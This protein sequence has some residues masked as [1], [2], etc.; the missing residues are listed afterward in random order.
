MVDGRASHMKIIKAAIYLGVI[1]FLLPSPPEQPAAQ[2]AALGPAGATPAPQPSNA[3][4]LAA[5]CAGVDD[6]SAFCT[7]QPAVCDTAR[8]LL[9]TLEAKAKYGI[10]LLYQWAE[11]PEPAAAPGAEAKLGDPIT[12]STVGGHQ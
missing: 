1:A 9:V 11:T 5:A 2:H 12:T 8:T 10:R 7:R 4:L 6:V 3:D